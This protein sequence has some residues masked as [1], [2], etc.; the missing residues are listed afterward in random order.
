M[1]L[2]LHL[3]HPG[4]TDFTPGMRRAS[5]N[6]T[7]NLLRKTQESTRSKRVHGVHPLRK[8]SSYLFSQVCSHKCPARKFKPFKQGLEDLSN[9][10]KTWV[11]YIYIYNIIYEDRFWYLLMGNDHSMQFLYTSARVSIHQLMSLGSF[12]VPENVFPAWKG[13]L[14]VAWF[15]QC[16]FLPWKFKSLCLL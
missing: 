8:T 11:M 5:W 15:P 12:S 2:I 10:E 4:F 16:F 9:S 13:F 7:R 3:F 14:S 1:F 6:S